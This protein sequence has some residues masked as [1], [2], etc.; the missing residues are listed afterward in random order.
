MLGGKSTYQLG[1]AFGDGKGQ[2]VP[3]EHKISEGVAISRKTSKIAW[4]NTRGQ[5]PDLLGEGES[6]VYTAEIVEEARQPKLAN[7][8]EILRA[9]G[10]Q[11]R[12]GRRRV[13][14]LSA[15]T[16]VAARLRVAWRTDS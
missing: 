11:Q 1:G 5:Y 10:P 2:P 4:S 16:A 14:D 12:P 13:R 6:I 15:E 9:I 8:K 3:L 7:K